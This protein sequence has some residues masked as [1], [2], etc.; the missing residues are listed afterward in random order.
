MPPCCCLSVLGVGCP[1]RFERTGEEVP[2]H[3]RTR[4]HGR[5]RPFRKSSSVAQTRHVQREPRTVEGPQP[6]AA[7][8][9]P[10]PSPQGREVGTEAIDPTTWLARGPTHRYR[11]AVGCPRVLAGAPPRGSAV[12]VQA[13]A[14]C[15]AMGAR[16][17]LGGRPRL[18]FSCRATFYTTLPGG[19]RQGCAV[20]QGNGSEMPRAVGTAF[21]VRLVC[22]VEEESDGF[23]DL[24]RK[25]SEPFR[26]SRTRHS[27]TPPPCRQH[28]RPADA[29]PLRRGDDQTRKTPL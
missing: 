29:G 13:A 23:T 8:P 9:G 10:L 21:S 4:S 20:P 16:D 14:A 2:P 6:R 1:V 12:Q 3:K 17:R 28:V 11:A 25:I 7:Q 15:E 19:G 18:P 26:K 24:L 22:S 27:T 5:R